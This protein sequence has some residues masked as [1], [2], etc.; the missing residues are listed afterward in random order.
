MLLIPMLA[1][2]DER[3]FVTLADQLTLPAG[4]TVELRAP[5]PLRTPAFSRAGDICLTLIAPLAQDT[6]GFRIRDGAG[7]SV[8]PTAVA[9]RAD[10]HT[11]S[12]TQPYYSGADRF[13]LSPTANLHPPY[14]AVRLKSSRSLH[15]GR[16]QWVSTDK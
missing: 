14:W 11:E 5:E 16:V 3:Q 6:A 10:G 9:V 7:L 13:C 4:R 2:A 12:L 15:V 8:V 1:C